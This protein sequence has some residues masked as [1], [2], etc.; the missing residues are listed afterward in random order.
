MHHTKNLHRERKQ[1]SN[2]R[3][4]Q[5]HQKIHAKVMVSTLPWEPRS[6]CRLG[7]SPPGEGMAGNLDMNPIMECIHLHWVD[8]P[9]R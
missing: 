2:S 9:N 3:H 7:P 1:K 6:W 8:L 4:L 5:R